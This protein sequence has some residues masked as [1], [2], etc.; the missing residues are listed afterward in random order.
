MKKRILVL[1]AVLALMVACMVFAVSAEI[2]ETTQ[3]CPC[4]CGVT[5]ETLLTTNDGEFSYTANGNSLKFASGHYVHTTSQ[6]PGSSL[7]INADATVVLYIKDSRLGKEAGLTTK[8]LSTITVNEGATLYIV[9]NSGEITGAY[10]SNSNGCAIYIYAGA[11]VELS[12]DLAIRP[13][14]GDK[15]TIKNGGM[16]Y[17]AG[18]LTIKDGVEITGGPNGNGGAI[19][20]TGA[21]AR[22]N[23]EGGSI[24]AD[25]SFAGSQGAAVSVYNNAVFNMTGGTI[26]NQSTNSKSGIRVQNAK[27][28]LQGGEVKA[29][30]GDGRGAFD[31]IGTSSTAV[32]VLVLA[33]D[34]SIS[35]E[36]G[37]VDATNAALQSYNS[38]YG[39]LYVANDWTG[40]GNITIGFSD[41]KTY[42][43]TYGKVS[44]VY[45][46]Q[47]GAWDAET[48]TFTQGGGHTGTLV[49]GSISA[50]PGLYG[51][52]GLLMVMRVLLMG[53]QEGS[54]VSKW[55]I[56]AKSALTAQ[57]TLQWDNAYVR[58]A[59]DT[60][61]SVPEGVAAIVD[62]NGVDCTDITLAEGAT[63][64]FWDKDAD[65]ETMDPSSATVTGE[66]ANA[67]CIAPDGNTY[68]LNGGK[69]YPVSYAISSISLR[70]G[71]EEASLYYTA[72]LKAHADAGVVG[73]VAVTVDENATT[74]TG[75]LGNYLYTQTDVTADTTANGVLIKGI[76]KNS[77]EAAANQSNAQR[78]IY[79]KAYI[80][81]GEEAYFAESAE[82]YKLDTLIAAVKA[83]DANADAVATMET[84]TWYQSIYTT[85][86]E[87]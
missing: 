27:F 24:T 41:N 40:H 28:Y 22:V 51:A 63:V 58:L 20:T 76:A 75:D 26:T 21:D 33:G 87:E 3:T 49:A 30:D 73:G 78:T 43:K 50:R 36:N 18:T 80:L 25:T 1:L 15:Q 59:C 72:T 71:E 38:G 74:G 47:C 62:L 34:G 52:D 17:N 8:T 85:V 66:G 4:G 55:Y 32:S 12:G 69:V 84:R 70:A 29:V 5:L 67:V 6:G 60:S 57:K 61:V 81:V 68:V 82:N 11:T 14:T 23:M 77:N 54:A 53:E 56:T 10:Y 44:D 13:G 35:D 39:S 42:G 64:A 83:D 37:T 7:S 48:E 9:G 19:Y 31:V 79:A 45:Y 46:A 65:W 2:D 16:I 86:D